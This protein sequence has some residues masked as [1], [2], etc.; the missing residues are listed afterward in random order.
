[1]SSQIVRVV[2]AGG[3]LDLQTSMSNGQVHLRLS[4]LSST[5]SI[6]DLGLLHVA[7]F[8]ENVCFD[9]SAFP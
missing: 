1:M 5:V 2:I 8:L 4:C 6:H 9:S 7:N 3:S